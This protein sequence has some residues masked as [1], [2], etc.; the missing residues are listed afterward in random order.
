VAVVAGSPVADPGVEIEPDPG[1]VEIGPDPGV[2]EIGPDPAVVAVG[3]RSR[4][5]RTT[6]K[7]CGSSSRNAS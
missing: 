5:A 1:V 7:Y 2:V 6:L 3:R 4:N